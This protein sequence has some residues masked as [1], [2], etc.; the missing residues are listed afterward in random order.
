MCDIDHDDH[1]IYSMHRY[2]K[3]EKVTSALGR[4]VVVVVRASSL[5]TYLKLSG[6]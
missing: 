1:T 2:A 5:I 4:V 6:N 3:T